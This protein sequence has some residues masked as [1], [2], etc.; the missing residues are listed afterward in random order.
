[1]V[2]KSQQGAFLAREQQARDESGARHATATSKPADREL[3]RR[4]SHQLDAAERVALQ[5]AQDFEIRVQARLSSFLRRLL[6]EQRN[7]VLGVLFLH[8]QDALEHAARGRI[9]RAE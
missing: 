4:E 9:V 3:P 5:L 6:L 1:E 8:R 7:Q 2:R